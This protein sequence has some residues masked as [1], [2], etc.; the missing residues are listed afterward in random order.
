M[1]V[2]GRGDII[3]GGKGM[4]ITNVKSDKKTLASWSKGAEYHTFIHESSEKYPIVKIK[5]GGKFGGIFAIK[6]GDDPVKYRDNKNKFY[7]RGEIFNTSDIKSGV[8]SSDDY[9]K[10]FV[11]KKLS[12]KLTEDENE[13]VIK[14]VLNETYVSDDIEQDRLNEIFG[15]YDEADIY[16]EVQKLRGLISKDLGATVVAMED[17]TG[18]SYLLLGGN[19]DIINAS[20]LDDTKENTKDSWLSRLFK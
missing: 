14:M 5:E 3:K 20:E 2:N 9:Y 13:A 11:E 19:D 8:R 17:E 12:V 4:G 10:S 6:E 1:Q 15:A 18:E 7:V 16:S